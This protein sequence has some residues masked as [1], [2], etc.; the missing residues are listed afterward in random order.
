MA[1]RPARCY[2]DWDRPYSRTAK[3][4]VNAAYVKGAPDPRI[5]SFDM[6]KLPEDKWLIRVD[7]GVDLKCQIR[8]NALEAARIGANKYLEKTLGR[9]NYHFKVRKYPHHVLREHAILSGAGADRLSQGMRHGF[10]KPKGRAIRVKAGEPILSVWVAN[11]AHVKVAKEAL[12]RAGA[13]FP[14]SP[15]YHVEELKP[16]AAA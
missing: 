6:G 4:K 13:K 8:D 14:G 1:L 16:K 5:R 15:V 11:P 10:G 2:R 9:E 12:R 7:M 3:R